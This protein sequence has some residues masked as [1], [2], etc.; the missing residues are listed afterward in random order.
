M[1]IRVIYK[2]GKTQLFIVASD[3]LCVDFQKLVEPL[4]GK[5][6]RMEFL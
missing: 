4:G 5:I 2:S 3:M 1:K 6:R